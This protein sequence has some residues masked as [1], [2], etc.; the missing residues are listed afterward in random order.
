MNA[1]PPSPS[2]QSKSSFGYNISRLFNHG[3]SPNHLKSNSEHQRAEKS[4]I[5]PERIFQEK[6]KRGRRIKQ[7][8]ALSCVN[9]TIEV[10]PQNEDY[11]RGLVP[12]K[13][14]SLQIKNR[15]L[16]LEIMPK[17]LSPAHKKAFARFS[18][19]S[20]KP[21]NIMKIQVTDQGLQTDEIITPISKTPESEHS[22]CYNAF[23]IDTWEFKNN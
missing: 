9:D 20:A 23:D 8:S 16:S 1:R 18:Q 2:A 17:N 15:D 19:K 7:L 5:K 10:S 6:N 4:Y 3:N 13:E 12:I 14:I 21:I 11:P 22:S